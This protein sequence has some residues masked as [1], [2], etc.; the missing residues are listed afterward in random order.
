MEFGKKMSVA[1]FKAK[2][3]SSRIDIKVNPKTGKSLMINDSGIMVGY[4]SPKCNLKDT[5]VISE[6][7]SEDGVIV[8]CMHNPGIRTVEAIASF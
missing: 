1:E 3:F 6:L 2:T 8:N 4:V 7:V 5:V